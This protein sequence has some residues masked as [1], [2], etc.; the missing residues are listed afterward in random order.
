M[1]ATIVIL[2]V[3]LLVELYGIKFQSQPNE[4]LNQKQTNVLR[5]GC[6]FPVIF[7]HFYEPYSN[8]LQVTIGRYAYIAVTLF[9]IFSAY[10]LEVRVKRKE[11]YL[12]HFLVKRFTAIL[13]PYILSSLIRLMFGVDLTYGGASFVHVL[14][15]Y[16]IIFYFVHIKIKNTKKR[17]YVLLLFTLCYSIVG[18]FWGYKFRLPKIGLNWYQEALGLTI[19]VFIAYHYEKM[20]RFFK[21]RV[22]VKLALWIPAAVF[23]KYTFDMYISNGYIQE[24]KFLCNYIYRMAAAVSVIVVIMLLFSHFSLGNYVSRQLGKISFEVFLYHGF[25]LQF[26]L[27]LPVEWNGNSYI[28]TVVVCTIIT[29]FVMN[30]IASVLAKLPLF[31]KWKG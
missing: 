24:Y 9:F 1:E 3:L 10:G 4:L 5:G 20:N 12:D 16:Y 11:D 29:A 17:E 28:L 27:K 6:C 21:N 26:L 13:I 25:Y 15:I 7:C 14:I 8:N 18:F 30:K 22:I 19:G 2:I 23:L 31:S